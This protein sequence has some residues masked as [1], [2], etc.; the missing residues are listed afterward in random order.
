MGRSEEK[1][2]WLTGKPYT[3]HY[4]D[5]GDKTGT[6]ETKTDWFTGKDYVQHYDSDHRSSGHSETKS[7]WFTGADYV[8]HYDQSD[9]SSGRSESKSDWL[10]GQPYDQHYYD[11]GCK[12]GTSEAR[13]D[14][15]TGERYVQ[16]SGAVPGGRAPSATQTLS[17][18]SAAAL[19]AIRLRFWSILFCSICLIQGSL[20]PNA[21]HVDIE[22]S[23]E[24][25]P[26]SMAPL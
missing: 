2:D 1:K 13:S 10:T 8:Q 24:A 15:L 5:S 6:S 9:Q 7:D 4:D 12:A 26:V 25:R 17:A 20:G 16:H 11:D 3:Q 19:S 21:P 22:P 14:W 23:N 18:S